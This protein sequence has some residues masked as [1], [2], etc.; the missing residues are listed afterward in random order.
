MVFGVLL[1]RGA[2]SD[3]EQ[4]VGIAMVVFS[5][6]VTSMFYDLSQIHVLEYFPDNVRV[7]FLALVNTLAILASSAVS[8]MVQ[9]A[10]INTSTF[11]FTFL[12]V[13]GVMAASLLPRKAF[14]NY[15]GPDKA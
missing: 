14:E 1:F 3:L 13:I 8:V 11:T 10:S 2:Y 9:V 4:T 6:L 5:N 15:A 7:T 12:C